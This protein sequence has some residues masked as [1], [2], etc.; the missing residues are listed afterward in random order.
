MLVP[1]ETSPN[2]ITARHTKG[3]PT[4][5]TTILRLGS[6]STISASFVCVPP[7]KVLETARR[8]DP[9][10]MGPDVSGVTSIA[11]LF[12]FG[13]FVTSLRTPNTSSTF[14][15][16]TTLALATPIDCTVT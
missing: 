1:P 13:T 9:T 12:H 15:V 10:R 6:N 16:I 2:S 8:R 4:L 5:L 11:F 3:P 7:P 14:R